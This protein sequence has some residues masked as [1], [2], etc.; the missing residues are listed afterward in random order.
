MNRSMVAAL[1]SGLV[2]PGA[3]QLFLRRP[4][5]A[6][7]FLVPAAVAVVFFVSSVLARA[8]AIVDQITAGTLPLDPATILA[9]VSRQDSGSSL[10][11]LCAIVMIG[12]WLAS[13]VDAYRLGKISRQ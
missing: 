2:F 9:E 4:K 5:R 3:G 8:S 6:L 10:D 1:L 7:C 12:C 13:I 11:T